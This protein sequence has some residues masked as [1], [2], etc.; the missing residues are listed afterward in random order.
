MQHST[1]FKGISSVNIDSHLY[2]NSPTVSVSKADFL[3]ASIEISD[4]TVSRTVKNAC[5]AFLS[6]VVFGYF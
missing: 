1:T 6:S 3:K 5:Y 4:K 2:L